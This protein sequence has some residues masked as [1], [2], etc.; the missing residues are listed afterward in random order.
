MMRRLGMVSVLLLAL[1]ACS[2]TAPVPEDHFYQLEA[3]SAADAMPSP[4]LQ[5]G[6]R[7]A[8]VNADP[9]RSGRAVLFRDARKPLEL[10]RYHYQYWVDQPPRMVERALLNYLRSIAVADPV[11]DDIR[12]G[13]T[14]YR[15]QTRLLR[16]EQVVG[17]GAPRVELELEATLYP[18]PSGAALWTAVYLRRVESSGNDMHA[19]AQAMQLALAQVFQALRAD[20]VAVEKDQE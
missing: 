13:S 10:Q 8:P 19:T 3:G 11:Q 15:L 17:E 6:L 1:A 14:A 18:E 9:L 7:V 4:A 2:A 5:G 16:F 20:L 12:R